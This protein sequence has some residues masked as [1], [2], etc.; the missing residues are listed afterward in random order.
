MIALLR[1]VRIDEPYVF[2]A[3]PCCTTA[4][5][6]TAFAGRHCWAAARPGPPVKI[7][8]PL[9]RGADWYDAARM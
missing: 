6:V 8:A 2:T 1:D 7:L 3:L 4:A 9:V 5:A